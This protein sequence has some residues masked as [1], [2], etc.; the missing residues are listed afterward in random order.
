MVSQWTARA[1]PWRCK[2]ISN[3]RLC[4]NAIDKRFSIMIFLNGFERR[5]VHHCTFRQIKG[6]ITI[7]CIWTNADMV[8]QMGILVYYAGITYFPLYHTYPG[9]CTICQGTAGTTHSEWY[10]HQWTAE[11]YEYKFGD[12]VKSTQYMPGA[13]WRIGMEQE[14]KLNGK[15]MYVSEECFSSTTGEFLHGGV[16]RRTENNRNIYRE[17]FLDFPDNIGVFDKKVHSYQPVATSNKQTEQV[18]WLF[19]LNMMRIALKT[20]KNKSSVRRYSIEF[21]W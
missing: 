16:N 18:G 17:G 8:G 14:E 9:W 3:D 13:A 12:D 10:M 15:G 1:L 4:G 2:R 11:A 7:G 6:E 5:S 20:Y 21:C 19:S